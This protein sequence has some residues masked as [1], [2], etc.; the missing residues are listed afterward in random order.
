MAEEKGDL[1]FADSSFD[2][3]FRCTGEGHQESEEDCCSEKYTLSLTSECLKH[4]IDGILCQLYTMCVDE[5]TQFPK[6]VS[7]HQQR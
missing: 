2:H 3:L 1:S 4:L 7:P 5:N 6:Q